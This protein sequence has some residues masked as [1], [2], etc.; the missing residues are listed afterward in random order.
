MFKSTALV[1][2]SAMVLAATVAV[3][4]IPDPDLSTATIIPAANGSVVYNRLDGAGSAFTQAHLANGT[5]VNATITLTLVNHLGAPLANHAAE[6]FW[7]ETTGD[8][9]VFPA[10]GT[11][12]DGPTNAV[13][14]T[15]WQQPLVAGGC[16]IGEG[17]IV[18]VEGQPLNQDAINLGFVSA[19]NNGDRIVN[20]ADLSTFAANYYGTYG[21]CSDLFYDGIL[22]LSDS[23][24]F[25]QA[26]GQSAP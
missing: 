19:D 15:V 9:L 16:S 3:A 24:L 20:L 8:S 18:L 21:P 4:D 22:N 25:A 10:G 14:V 7:L 11:I 13:G 2:V 26:Y 1:L 5:V 17:V 23:A 6:D 12:A